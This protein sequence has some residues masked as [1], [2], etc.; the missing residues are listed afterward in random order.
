MET[1]NPRTIHLKLHPTLPLCPLCLCQ[2]D[3]IV[4]FNPSDIKEIKIKLDCRNACCK[5]SQQFSINTK[6]QYLNNYTRHYTQMLN[7]SLTPKN[8]E[9]EADG[10]GFKPFELFPEN[11]FK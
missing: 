9:E 6:S 8:K 11:L 1:T 7:N 5:W 2:I 4:E 10:M 3:P